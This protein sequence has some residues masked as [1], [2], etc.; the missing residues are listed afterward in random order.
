MLPPEEGYEKQIGPLYI[1]E[2]KSTSANVSK[3]TWYLRQWQQLE[4]TAGLLPRPAG[5]PLMI[6][7]NITTYELKAGSFDPF[8]TC[9]HANQQITLQ[10]ALCGELL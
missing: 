4:T 1:A 9:Y 8:L 10:V 7:G 3:T 6:L 2:T 5:A